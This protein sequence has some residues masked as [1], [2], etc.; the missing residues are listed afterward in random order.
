MDE[1]SV[2]VV[3]TSAVAAGFRLAGLEVLEAEDPVEARNALVELSTD[4]EVGVALVQ[5]ELV[6]DVIGLERELARGGGL[7]LVPF[8]G[9]LWAERPEGPRDFVARILRRAVGYRVRL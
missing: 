6:E 5:E 7:T 9:P 2:A 1:V 3:S 4:P 8:P